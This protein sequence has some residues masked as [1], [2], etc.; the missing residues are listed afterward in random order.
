MTSPNQDPHPRDDSAKGNPQPAHQAATFGL[1]A[2]GQRVTFDLVTAEYKSPALPRTFRGDITGAI[3]DFL[4]INHGI[5]GGCS[6]SLG[7]SASADI[8]LLYSRAKEFEGIDIC[9]DPEGLSNHR[10]RALDAT[11]P[12]FH[13]NSEARIWR[14]I[15]TTERGDFA[16]TRGD[17]LFIPGLGKFEILE[18]GQ[19]RECSN[20]PA[21]PPQLS[22][23]DVSANDL[24]HGQTRQLTER[25]RWAL[26]HLLSANGCMLAPV[27]VSVGR[28]PDLLAPAA[29][30]LLSDRLRL[31]SASIKPRHLDIT[32]DESTGD[33]VAHPRGPTWHKLV[34]VVEGAPSYL[35]PENTKIRLAHRG[36]L[37]LG[38]TFR[39][40]LPDLGGPRYSPDP[41][42]LAKAIMT[43]WARSLPDNSS[44]IL[45]NR[46]FPREGATAHVVLG[47]SDVPFE[48]SLKPE[49][50]RQFSAAMTKQSGWEVTL[51]DKSMTQ[52]RILSPTGK[53]HSLEPGDK[54]WIPA[55]DDSLLSVGTLGAVHGIP[56]CSY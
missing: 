42:A 28:G 5:V 9:L 19:S 54:I 6:F 48:I 24:E 22:R 47:S 43:Y 7:P 45:S 14:E 34:S 44:L 4:H 33:L 17:A 27:E 35:L 55:K 41:K 12:I 20:A 50:R 11:V 37:T 49:L 2:V 30:L 40:E 21:M 29:R 13:W 1:H 25:L 23:I 8:E 18:P 56:L 26:T 38:G 46:C 53:V 10:I 31:D 36:S 32:R 3:A 39:M 51:S 52:A 16:Y 15:A